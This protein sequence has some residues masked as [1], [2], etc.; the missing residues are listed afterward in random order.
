MTERYALLRIT[1]DDAGAPDV[2]VVEVC[3]GESGRLLLERMARKMNDGGAPPK[4]GDA[5]FVV[6][7]VGEILP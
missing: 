6:K 3:P 2:V 5:L 7:R 4:L 1:W